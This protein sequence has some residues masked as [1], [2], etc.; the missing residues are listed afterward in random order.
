MSFRIS[1]FRSSSFRS[2][3]LLLAML[4]PG[5]ATAQV[6][7]Q[8]SGTD[9]EFRALHAPAGGVVWAGGQGGRYA[10]TTDGG[11]TWRAGSIPGAGALF[12]TG[13]WATPDALTAHVLATHFEGGLARVY[14]TDDGGASWNMQWE[15]SD[16]GVFM[17]ALQCWRPSHC[18]AFG[19]PIPYAAGDA[20]IARSGDPGA[21]ATAVTAADRL[22]VI[23]TTD[24]R[25]WQRI[26]RDA[27]PPIV[28]GEAGFAAS[29]TTL[30]LRGEA[31]AWIATGAGERARVHMTHDGGASWSAAETPLAAG[32]TAGMFGIAFRDEH[33]GIA[34]G[35]DYRRRTEQQQNVIRT[36]DGG[37]TWTPAGAALPHGVRYGVAYSDVA[38]TVLRSTGQAL[39]AP[40]ADESVRPLVAVGP[41][42][43]GLSRDDGASWIVLDTTAWNTVAFAGG[44]AWLAGPR[45]RIARVPRDVV[46]GVGPR[47][48]V[49]GAS[50]S[51]ATTDDARQAASVTAGRAANA[52]AGRAPDAADVAQQYPTRF[53]TTLVR[54][55]AVADALAWIEANFEEQ[56]EEWIRITEIPGT[57]RH[58]QQRAAYV[59]AQLEAE[60]LVVT[61]DSIGNVSARRPG[62][63]GG[64]TVVFAAHMDTVH[65]LDTDVSVARDSADVAGRRSRVLRAPG[66]FDNS[67]SV[68]NM[69]A[70]VRAMN[71][72]NVQTRGD[73]I[74]IATAQEELGLLGMDYWLEQNPGV[75]DVLIA[76]DGGLPNVNYGAL[77]IYWTRYSFH[78]EGSHTNTSAGR[79]HPARALAD[80]IRDIYTIEIPDYM[81]GA[82]YN[83]GMLDGGKIF[84]AIPEQVSFTMDLRSVNPILLNDLDAQIDSA[85]ARAARAHGVEW[86]K[87]QQ[88][89]NAAGGTAQMLEDRRRHPLIQTALDVHGHL[90]IESRAIATGS[91]D[92]N[93]GVVRGIPSISIGRSIGG[94]QHTLS[95]WSEVDSALPATKIVLLIGAAM[96]GLAIPGT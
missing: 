9:A 32:E 80:A 10:V 17:D 25:T 44:D 23:R 61:I 92:A 16:D 63:G 37:R 49:D 85:V 31:T 82:V 86:R 95:E 68:A 55:P 21:A 22:M 62:T 11:A 88:L 15:S 65:P 96:A 38:F 34:V 73:I 67:A 24:G 46:F 75:A 30:A 90:G 48:E 72:A 51:T 69:L 66:I 5:P 47:S 77:G 64:E 87:A 35:G 43:A 1:S 57:S 84:N 40:P 26:P 27:L 33:N 71:R 70:V 20:D 56:V 52:A 2:M 45:G 29:G 60:G 94:D 18:I 78:G 91:T 28:S 76:L 4:W 3:T 14:R 54:Q 59:R 8:Q 42:G 36:S 81:G 53:D 7:P 74:F 19:D 12:I 79:P 83:V 41:S 39:N 6:T 50:P 89:R 13:L 58:E 93:A